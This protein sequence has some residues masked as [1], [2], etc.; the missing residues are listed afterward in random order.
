MMTPGLAATIMTVARNSEFLAEWRRLTGAAIGAPKAA[1]DAM[2]DES[3]GRNRSD[4]EAFA[5]FVRKYV[6]ERLTPEVRAEVE[7]LAIPV[8]A[9]E[10]GDFTKGNY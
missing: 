3:T 6:W 9:D 8:L 4:A 10:P 1:I 2:I 5:E 7:R